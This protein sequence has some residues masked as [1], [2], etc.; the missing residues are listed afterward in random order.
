MK[1]GLPLHLPSAVLRERGKALAAV[2]IAALSMVSLPTCSL[3]VAAELDGGARPSDAGL[4]GDAGNPLSDAGTFDA[5]AADASDAGAFVPLAAGDHARSATVDGR[6]RTFIVH[7]PPAVSTGAPLPLVLVFHGGNGTG[8]AVQASLGFDAPADAT[9]FLVVYPDGIENNWNDGRG[10]TDAEIAG[11]DDVVFVRALLDD[12][13]AVVDV[14]EQRLFATG[15][16]NGGMFSHRL[17]CELADRLVAVA[18][19]IAAMPT[20]LASTCAPAQQISVF[21]VQGSADPFIPLAGGDTHHQNFPNLGDGG[22][23]ESAVATRALW[24]ALNGC[25]TEVSD[26]LVPIDAADPSRVTRYILRACTGSVEVDQYIIAGM[27]HTWPPL[28]GQAPAVSGPTSSQLDATAAIVAF[29]S[30]KVR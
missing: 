19:V 2:A 3:P 17:G 25:G 1:N 21:M 27:G 30:T 6:L 26:A 10:T 14:D 8:A 24:G 12:V 23:V 20:P 29:F 4:A 5:G 18:P 28:P 22:D 13:S 9:G 15:V 16:S 11:V 7:V